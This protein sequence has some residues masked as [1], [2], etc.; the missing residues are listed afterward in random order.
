[1]EKTGLKLKDTQKMVK[2]KGKNLIIPPVNFEVYRLISV[3]GTFKHKEM[4]F[5]IDGKNSERSSFG[6][7]NLESLVFSAN[8][9]NI[10]NYLIKHFGKDYEIIVDENPGLPEI[11]LPK[12]EITTEKDV[13]L[14]SVDI[15]KTNQDKIKEIVSA[16]GYVKDSAKKHLSKELFKIGLATQFIGTGGGN[17]S[18]T[19]RMENAYSKLGISNTGNYSSDDIIYVSSNGNRGNRFINVESGKL[20]GAYENIDKAISA[21]SRF[22]MDTKS[23]LD[24]TSA[25]NIGEVAMADYLLSKGYTRDDLSGIC[26]SNN[27]MNKAFDENNQNTEGGEN[28]PSCKS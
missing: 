12:V 18:T 28:K 21:N 7:N 8:N 17:D 10:E 19:Q 20:N 3:K 26:S 9:K 6:S 24:K 5:L 14:Q 22:I 4:K 16:P 13:T 2:V 15:N 11:I 25:Y 1:M 23:H 27:R